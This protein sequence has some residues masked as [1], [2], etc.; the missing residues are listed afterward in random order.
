LNWAKPS[1]MIVHDL[2]EKSFNKKGG[3]NWCW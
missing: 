3:K 2:Q 1:N